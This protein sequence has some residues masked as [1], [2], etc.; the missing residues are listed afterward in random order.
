MLGEYFDIVMVVVMVV[1]QLVPR[2]LPYELLI[3]DFIVRA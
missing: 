2:E 3:L 1:V